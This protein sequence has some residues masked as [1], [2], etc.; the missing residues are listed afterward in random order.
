[1]RIELIDL[2]DSGIGGGIGDVVS[3][4]LADV[5]ENFLPTNDTDLAARGVEFRDA[6]MSSY[7]ETAFSS[8]RAW[9]IWS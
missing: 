2:N 3:S 6:Q 4:L 8:A 7:F 9:S 5:V 1:M